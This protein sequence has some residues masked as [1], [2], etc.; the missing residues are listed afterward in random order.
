MIASCGG[1]LA[2]GARL[3][4]HPTTTADPSDCDEL[5]RL[6]CALI[7]LLRRIL[8]RDQVERRMVDGCSLIGSSLIAC[9]IS[10]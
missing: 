1:A 9:L 5:L 2:N 3:T 7:E 4:T 8:K 6:D 10:H